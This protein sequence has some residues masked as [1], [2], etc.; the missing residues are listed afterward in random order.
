M[1]KYG[2]LCRLNESLREGDIPDLDTNSIKIGNWLDYK[3]Y[4]VKVFRNIHSNSVGLSID[5]E[6]YGVD[7]G[8]ETLYINLFPIVLSEFVLDQ[9]DWDKSAQNV[10]YI[11]PNFQLEFKSGKSIL[12][13]EGCFK[14]EFQ[15]L[16]VLQNWFSDQGI[17][18][19][20]VWK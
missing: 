8:V 13:Q 16:H 12:R 17:T 2:P 14:G 20:I 18:L 15:Y 5:K 4:P 6:R 9:I 3:C 1:N 10:Y 7:P 19:K 11:P